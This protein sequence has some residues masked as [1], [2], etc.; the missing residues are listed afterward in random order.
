M[1]SRPTERVEAMP[2]WVMGILGFMAVLAVLAWSPIYMFVT[3]RSY[4]DANWAF[5]G[6]LI[7]IALLLGFVFW[8]LR[9][10]WWVLTFPF[11]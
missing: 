3:G 5:F 11:H 9:A 8:V 6:M 7:G 1:R 2:E 10:L 4:E